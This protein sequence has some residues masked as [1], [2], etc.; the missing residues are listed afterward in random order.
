[1]KRTAAGLVLAAIISLAVW[2]Y[3]NDGI[4]RTLI[5]P[6][7]PADARLDSIRRYFEAWGAAGPLAYVLIV[8]VEVVLAPIPGTLLYLPGGVIFGWLT[9][10]AA[11]LAGNVIGAGL[12]CQIMRT[13][14]RGYVA[15]YL[16]SGPLKKYE[17]A[18]EKR[19]FWLVFLLRVNPLTSS[20]IVSYAAGMT[21]LPVWKVMAGTLF[22][23]APLCFAQ[24]YFAQEIFTAFPFLVYPL[25][26]IGAVYVIYVVTLLRRLAR[27]SEAAKTIPIANNSAQ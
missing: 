26:L 23:M 24:S 15:P 21:R 8:T 5:Q 7:I 1:M 4:F 27:L 17:T 25:V 20:D 2:S 12:A 16:E 10:G 13:L 22:G 6:D 9:G 11:A 14:A 3:V 18:I 19:G